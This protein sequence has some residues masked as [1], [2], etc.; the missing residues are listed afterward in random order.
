[1]F[2]Q[3]RNKNIQEKHLNHPQVD[4]ENTT[5]DSLPG[6]QVADYL[7]KNYPCLNSNPL[8]CKWTQQTVQQEPKAKYCLKCN[9]PTTLVEKTKLRGNRGTY[10]IEN[11]LGGRG[12]GRLYQGIQIS[13][14]QPVVIKE[15]LLPKK[16]F[17]EG[18]SRQS[19]AAFVSLA[20]VKLADGR[21]QDFRL[22][23]PWEAIADPIEERCYLVTKGNLD[24]CQTLSS[25]LSIKGAMSTE[26]VRQVLN[27]VLQTLE[28]LHEQKYSLP[29]LQVRE[30]IAHGNLSLNSL[31]IDEQLFFIYLCDLGLW[32]HLFY[33][34]TIPMLNP[35]PVDDLVALGYVAFYLLAGKTVDL[36]GQPLDPKD[37][38]QWPLVNPELKAFILCL[39]GIGTPFASANTARQSLLKLPLDQVSVATLPVIS[40]EAGVKVSRTPWIVLGVLSSLLLLGGFLWFVLSKPHQHQQSSNDFLICCIKDVSPLPKGK[41]I[42]TAQTNGTWSYV[43]QQPNLILEG[44][45]LET[46][47]Q[48]RQLKSQLIY[49]PNT[50]PENDT[51]LKQI[52][53][54]KADF[55]ITSLIDRQ[56]DNFT[57][58]EFAYDGLVV[59][60]NFSYADRQKSLPEALHGQITFEQLRQLYTGQITNW[61]QLGGPDLP[62]KLYIPDEPEAIQ[63]FEQRVLKEQYAIALFRSLQ[64]NRQFPNITRLST[65]A[66][67]REVIKDFEDEQVGGIAFGTLSKVFDQCSAYPLALVNGGTPVQ[68]LVQDNQQPVTPKTD[69]CN[70]KGSYRPNVQVFSTGSYPLGYPIAVVYARDNSRSPVG[71]RF[72]NILRTRESQRLLSKTGLVPL[73]P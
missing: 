59:F 45:T 70:K 21:N 28:F 63:I 25:Y 72:A 24:N 40:A 48:K 37:N 54:G 10:V 41:F 35:L 18:E 12:M 5:D 14:S 61:Q 65:F 56:N 26:Q 11:F 6:E 31:L 33:P 51:V 2:Q 39:L 50:S 42:Y 36:S 9:F 16:V 17:N 27:Q 44:T 22:L 71:A 55:G 15:Y 34:P 23:S 66:T 13:D 73:A 1:M 46:E 60:V 64:T 68:A 8:S 32:E 67:L 53:S 20:G 19:K 4:L 52:L 30:G 38:Q 47:L 57:Y 49:Q 62:V 3:F 7:Y 69:L 43:L 29:S 58:A